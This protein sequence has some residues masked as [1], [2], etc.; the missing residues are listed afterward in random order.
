MLRR[1]DEKGREGGRE[2]GMEKN[3]EVDI[4]SLRTVRSNRFMVFGFFPRSRKQDKS[5]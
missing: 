2:G 5:A 1:A 3:M 4:H